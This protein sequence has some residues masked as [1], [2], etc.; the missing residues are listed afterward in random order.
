MFF[1]PLKRK[2]ATER[3]LKYGRCPSIGEG[4]ATGKKLFGEARRV[5]KI[6]TKGIILGTGVIW[7]R[8]VVI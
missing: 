3:Q 6:C 4:S 2:A 7:G 5:K 1:L 8:S